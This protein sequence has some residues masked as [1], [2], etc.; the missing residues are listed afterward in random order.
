V[1]SQTSTI[2]M[3]PEQLQPSVVSPHKDLKA[4][5]WEVHVDDDIK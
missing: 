2:K 5:S 3:V 4:I 1:G